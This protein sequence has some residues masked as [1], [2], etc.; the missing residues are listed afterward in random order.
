MTTW[1]ISYH[2]VTLELAV[3]LAIVTVVFVVRRLANLD[4]VTIGRLNRSQII[5]SQLDRCHI[6]LNNFH[7]IQKATMTMMKTFV[8]DIYLFWNIVVILVGSMD[9]VW[10]RLPWRS[11]PISSIWMVKY[12]KKTI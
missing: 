8:K 2:S 6:S 1:S 12:K 11:Y 4:I 9:G 3:L 10:V 7:R 5:L